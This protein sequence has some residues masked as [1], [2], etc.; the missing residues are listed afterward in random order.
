M[1]E[2]SSSFDKIV[3]AIEKPKSSGSDGVRSKRRTSKSV[4]KEMRNPD[5]KIDSKVVCLR[6]QVQEEINQI[7]SKFI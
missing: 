3:A 1:K 7:R 5:R 2:S 4:Q 6:K